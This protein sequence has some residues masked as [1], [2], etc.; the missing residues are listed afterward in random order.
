MIYPL[1]AGKRAHQR[2][3]CHSQFQGG[4]GYI[5]LGIEDK[6]KRVLG[7]EPKRY[8]EEQIQQ[9]ITTAVTHLC[10]YQ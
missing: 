8:T 2:R 6:T 1:K 3:Y 9:I 4:R 7:I 10:R 5:I